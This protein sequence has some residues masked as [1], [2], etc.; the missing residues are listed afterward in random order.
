MSVHNTKEVP[1]KFH[2][3]AASV[4]HSPGSCDLLAILTFDNLQNFEVNNMFFEIWKD[5][6][7]IISYWLGISHLPK[8]SQNRF[9]EPRHF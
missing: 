7:E 3:H 8:K 2:L 9:N 6:C 1:K 4:P 5:L